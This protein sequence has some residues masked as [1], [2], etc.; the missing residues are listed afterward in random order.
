[1]DRGDIVVEKAMDRGDIVVE[2]AMD[3]GE[4]TVLSHRRPRTQLLVGSLSS[5]RERMGQKGWMTVKGGGKS[6]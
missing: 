2:K 5:L 6:R 4:L 1:M 3:R